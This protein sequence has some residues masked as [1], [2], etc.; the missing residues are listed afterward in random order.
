MIDRSGQLWDYRPSEVMP[1]ARIVVLRSDWGPDVADFVGA[2]V[3]HRVI[4]VDN[5]RQGDL[6]ENLEHD[7]NRWENRPEYFRRFA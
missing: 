2:A 7:Q 3:F 5:H 1:W 6:L 4:Y